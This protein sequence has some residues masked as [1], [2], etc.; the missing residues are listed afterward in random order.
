MQEVGSLQLHGTGTPL[1]DPVEVGAAIAV[2]RAPADKSATSSQH[3]DRAL[4]LAA[5]KSGLGHTEPAAGAVGLMHALVAL[6]QMRQQPVL[7]LAEVCRLFVLLAADSSPVNVEACWTVQS[8]G[9]VQVNPF[10][11]A[12]LGSAAVQLPRQNS[13]DCCDCTRST[14]AGVSAFAFQGTNAHAIIGEQCHRHPVAEITKTFVLHSLV[15]I[16]PAR[17]CRLQTSDRTSA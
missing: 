11:S 1:G 6:E 3:T 12:C 13:S 17:A 4:V 9:R 16:T 8:T 7:H 5:C 2:L 15:P 10:V 14:A